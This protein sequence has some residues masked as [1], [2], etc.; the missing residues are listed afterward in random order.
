MFKRMF[1][2]DLASNNPYISI[3]MPKTQPNQT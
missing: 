1:K 2:Q 3:K